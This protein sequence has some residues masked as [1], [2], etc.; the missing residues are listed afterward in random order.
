MLKTK[1]RG[2]KSSGQH[3]VGSRQLLL[4]T[5]CLLLTVL[6]GCASSKGH[7]TLLPIANPFPGYNISG[8]TITFHNKDIKIS[9]YPLNA[10]ETKEMLTMKE[11][12]SPLTEILGSPKY[13]IFSMEI[14][15][16]SNAKILYNPALTTLFDNSMG[17]HK[18]MDFTDLYSIFSNSPN[19]EAALKNF[20]DMLYDLGVTLGPGQRVSRLLIF[21]GIEEESSEFTIEMKEVYISTSTISA[22][23]SFKETKAPSIVYPSPRP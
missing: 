11:P 19:P 15:N 18:P 12:N 10:P 16:L 23:F 3:A 6:T 20:K 13:L 4:T 22:S 5:Y 17:F 9:I 7:T 1:I 14:E 2:Q 8:Q 21:S